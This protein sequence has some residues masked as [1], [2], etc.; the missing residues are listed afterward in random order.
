MQYLLE[1][2]G[3]GFYSF[4]AKNEKKARKSAKRLAN[5]KNI[6]LLNRENEDGTLTEIE[7]HN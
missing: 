3:D 5:G 2:D 1:T 4:E 7:L 6:L